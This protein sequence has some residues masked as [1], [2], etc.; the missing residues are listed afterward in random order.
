MICA[1]CSHAQADHRNGRACVHLVT[2]F[3]SLTPCPCTAY[4]DVAV[5]AAPVPTDAEL[6]VD[7]TVVEVRERLGD[8]TDSDL[9]RAAWDAE[10]AGKNRVV[11]SAQ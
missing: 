6:M 8:I 2:G 4:T 3:N 9:L 11:V 7:G 1:N 10:A 5:V